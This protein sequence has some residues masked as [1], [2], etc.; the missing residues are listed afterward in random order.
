MN[1]VFQ[2]N[3]A[4]KSDLELTTEMMKLRREQNQSENDT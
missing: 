3:K 2:N 4:Q 1:P